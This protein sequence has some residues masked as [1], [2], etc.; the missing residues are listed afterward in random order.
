MGVV[1]VIAAGSAKTEL[2]LRKTTSGPEAEMV[3]R[4]IDAYE[5]LARK[6]SWKQDVAI[7]VEPRLNAGYPDLVIAHYDPKR[8]SKQALACGGLSTVDLKV[9]ACLLNR[10]AQTIEQ[11]A[12]STGFESNYIQESLAKLEKRAVA[13]EGTH[14]WKA[15]QKTSLFVLTKLVS[16]EAK[17][18][19]ASMAL[20][21]ALRN[22]SFSST[23]YALLGTDSISPQTR[24]KYETLGVGVIAGEKFETVVQPRTRKIPICYTSL[25]L[26]EC[27]CRK[28]VMEAS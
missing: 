28:R 24:E 18:S 1:E 21:Q 6:R 9:L 14:C 22:T 8:I 23:S 25:L 4:F 17:V 12:L 5:C 3:K 2:P 19:D 7:F 15:S 27:I 10:G 11:L 20:S 26:N 16:I 13:R